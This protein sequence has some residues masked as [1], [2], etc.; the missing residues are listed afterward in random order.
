M[1]HKE[2]QPLEELD[3]EIE[4]IRRLMLRSIEE[5]SS[6]EKMSTRNPAIVAG[7]K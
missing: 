1:Q 3:R 5:T 6:E 7:K 2:S 4:E